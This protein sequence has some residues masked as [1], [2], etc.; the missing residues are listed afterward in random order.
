MTKDKEFHSF[1]Q[2]V[3]KNIKKQREKAG[4]TQEAIADLVEYKYYQKIEAGKVNI[5][6]KMVYKICRKL[7]IKPADL[8]KL[9]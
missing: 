4:L 8:F 6:L 2:T 3:G 5:T 7:N 1:L 9:K